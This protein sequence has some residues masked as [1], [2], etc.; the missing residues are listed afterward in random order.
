MFIGRKTRPMGIATLGKVAKPTLVA[1]ARSIDFDGS[2]DYID[3]GYS[4]GTSSACTISF[5]MKDASLTTGD[6]YV[7]NRDS[8]SDGITFFIYNTDKMIFRVNGN[9]VESTNS[10]STGWN[11]IVGVFND[12]GNTKKIY[13][14][15]IETSA[16]ET[17]SLNISGNLRIG[18]RSY[19]ISNYAVGNIDEVAIWSR[20][21][22]AS[23][24]S[25]IYQHQRMNLAKSSV[26][27][28][29]N[30]LEG[31]WRMGDGD[32][33][34]YIA[35]RRKT[36]FTGKSIDFDG[37]ND[38][39]S[40]QDNNDYTFGDG[41]SDSAFSIYAWI[42]MDD[43]TN[44][45]ILNKGVYN[46]DAEWNFR[47]NAS[48]K[49]IVA[50]YDESVS[51][52]HESLV[53]DSAITAYEGSWIHVAATYD[54][55]G[56]TSANSGLTLY[57]N[58]SALAS[59]TADAGTYVAMEN[60]GGDVYIGKMSSNYANGKITDVAIWNAEL[61]A[62]DISDIYNSGEPTDLTL[63]ASYDTDR[64]SNLKGYWRMGNGT[65]DDNNIAGNGLIG[66]QTNT[67]TTNI[68]LNGNESAL[69]NVTET[70]LSSITGNLT[71]GKMYKLVFTKTDT[72]NSGY[73]KWREGGGSYTDIY[74]TSALGT[75]TYTVYFQATESQPL[76]WVSG[77]T[78]SWQGAITNI[79]LEE[80]N[81]NAGKMINMASDAISELAPNRHTGTMTNMA[82]GDIE[83]DVP[84]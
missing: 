4:L 23:E 18:A 52:T 2:N 64:T 43:A 28:S 41:S 48:D 69:A 7:D 46:T 79:S 67:T 42:N 84:S 10:L 3:T 15:N 29:S 35:D 55:T 13:V 44:F 5:W 76:Q 82:S 58:G 11:H 12:S 16:S 26:G 81:G 63:A 9:D 59:S 32:T 72:V 66:D 78:P 49:L 19:S 77:G 71:A 17:S 8:A 50:L 37:S 62:T 47:T 68:S 22:K 36:F 75:G 53:S 45:T 1:N 31:W 34:P 27:Y 65:L 60:L 40:I 83:T 6:N 24:I 30:N 14:N 25:K 80:Y 51:S 73:D 39:I 20:V 33:Y 74:T 70:T 54:G 56:G 38:Y 21:L 57:L 61:S